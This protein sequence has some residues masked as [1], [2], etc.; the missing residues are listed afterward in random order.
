MR[1]CSGLTLL[2]YLLTTLLFLSWQGGIRGADITWN[3]ETSDDWF[4]AANWDGNV[5][6]GSSDT[7]IISGS[8]DS[9]Q[10]A[11]PVQITSLNMSDG[12]LTG[13][14]TT[15]VATGFSAFQ[16]GEITGT[17]DYTF[18]ID[19]GDGSGLQW[20]GGNLTTTGT[21]NVFDNFVWSGGTLDLSDSETSGTLFLDV[22]TG[23]VTNEV[24][25]ESGHIAGEGLA[26]ADGGQVNVTGTKT[27]T[28]SGTGLLNEGSIVFSNE[29]QVDLGDSSSS[30]NIL[31]NTTGSIEFNGTT[32]IKDNSTTQTST[33]F[34]AGTIINDSDSNETVIGVNVQQTTGGQIVVQSGS[35]ALEKGGSFGAD[36]VTKIETP[37]IFLDTITAAT[38]S[39]PRIEFRN[40]SYSFA[41]GSTIQNLNSEG[42]IAITGGADVLVAG[43]FDNRGNT[44][45]TDNSTLVLAN[46]SS[47]SH[48][49]AIDNGSTV[50]VS[51]VHTIQGGEWTDGTIQGFTTVPPDLPD[52][53]ASVSAA[54]AGATVPTPTTFGQTVVQLGAETSNTFN[55]STSE[56]KSLTSHELVNNDRVV[57]S[58]GTLQLT[59]SKITNNGNWFINNS[60]I[61]SDAVS[62]FTNTGILTVNNTD[63]DTT[64]LGAYYD[65]QGGTLLVESGNFELQGGGY[66]DEFSDVFVG[67]DDGSPSLGFVNGDYTFAGNTTNYSTLVGTSNS[68]IEIANADV[69]ISGK[70]MTEGTL[71]VDDD[72]VLTID[73]VPDGTHASVTNLQLGSTKTLDIN[74]AS[75]SSPI[76]NGKGTLV[77]QGGTWAEGE[78]AGDG[79]EFGPFA[80]DGR[81]SSLFISGSGDKK[82]TNRTMENFGNIYQQSS[83]LQL[84]GAQIQ[85]YGQWNFSI[86]SYITDSGESDFINFGEIYAA[87][88]ILPTTAGSDF[89]PAG[90]SGVNISPD[91]VNHGRVYANSG[92]LVFDGTYS[93][94]SNVFDIESDYYMIDDSQQTSVAN[95][96]TIVFNQGATFSSGRITGDGEIEGDL[97]ISNTEIEPFSDFFSLEDASTDFGPQNYILGYGATLFFAGN[98][99]LDSTAEVTLKILGP[100]DGEFDQIQTSGTFNINNATLNIES[101]N[102]VASLLTSSDF[103]PILEGLDGGELV[104]LFAGLT[105]G[106]LVNIYDLDENLLGQFN[107]FYSQFEVSLTNFQPVPEPETYAL[108]LVGLGVIAWTVRKR[109]NA[110][111]S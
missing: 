57:Q 51:G 104:G 80:V 93:Q 3:G 79:Q 76:I 59:N 4:T 34:N 33:L 7:A 100:S 11:S 72:S 82:L 53:P 39:N 37:I 88:S 63:P 101:P 30:T 111:V 23:G 78:I 47:N 107:I 98:V 55:I 106:S 44:K 69:L 81:T 91:F 108:L 19:G 24:T 84:S 94:E 60:T 26:V 32:T 42:E 68:V 6:P 50:Q 43:T 73:L 74:A 40:E 70:L 67:S 61:S 56:D 96:A 62:V 13:V 48:F 10:F 22:S 15:F 86:G 41:S 35:L 109:R 46:E 77:I 92:F 49:L 38:V 5:T 52:L 2:K 83:T 1:L 20:S 75:V 58:D 28:I 18:G 89:A 66:I 95:G 17:S 110:A 31:N 71:S 97:T 14:T 25:W 99:D 9:A 54:T 12:L 105:N 8:T 65:S 29:P 27:R 16:G 90:V 87:G 85:N 45:L 103:F 102:D 36:S 64:S 21:V